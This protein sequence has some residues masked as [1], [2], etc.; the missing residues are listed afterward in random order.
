LRVPIHLNATDGLFE[1]DAGELP[2]RSAFLRGLTFEELT[3][4]W[5]NPQ[6][7]RWHRKTLLVKWDK[8]I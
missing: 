7:D 3:V 5:P 8:P 6:D 1:V 4:A 2:R